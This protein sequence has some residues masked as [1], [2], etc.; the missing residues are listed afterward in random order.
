MA[1]K[2]KQ[3]KA[4]LYEGMV[5]GLSNYVMRTAEKDNPTDTELEAMVEVTK[6]LFRTV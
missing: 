1:K 3:K 2:N 5:I 6:I 4:N